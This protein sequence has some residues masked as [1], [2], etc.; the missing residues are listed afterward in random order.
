M[1]S[2]ASTIPKW[3]RHMASG[4]VEVAWIVLIFFLLGGGAAPEVN[5]P[6]YVC[7]AK[8]FWDAGF[9]PRDLFLRSQDAHAVF[10]GA[11]GGVTRWVDLPTAAWIGRFAGWLLLAAA[12]YRLSAAL[13][14]HRGASLL[15][16][17]LWATLVQRMH[18]SGEWIIG[19]IEGK[20]VAYALVIWGLSCWVQGR[21]RWAWTLV[22]G[23]AT[24]HVLV[25]GWTAIAMAFAAVTQ[26]A[27]GRRCL[28]RSWPGIL[29]GG[30]ISLAG[31][32]PAL[33]LNADVSADVM[34]RAT[35][36]YVFDRISHH[37]LIRDFDRLFV[38]RHLLLMG[39][40]VVLAQ[41]LRGRPPFARLAGVVWGAM[42]LVLVGATLDLAL[43]DSVWTA[44][45]MRYYWFRLSDVFVP[46]GVSL[47]VMLHL[48]H[49]QTRDRRLATAGLALV[50]LVATGNLLATVGQLHAATLPAA[51]RQGG[52]PD[53]AAL[54]DWRDVC[55]WVRLHL[56]NDALCLTP[57]DHQT[58]KWYAQR[59]ELVTWKDVPQDA[60]SIVQWSER[61][62]RVRRWQQSR[63]EAEAS[64][65]F[66][67][68][69]HDYG[70]DH[71]VARWPTPFPVA[72][73]QVIYQN[74]GYAVLRLA[75]DD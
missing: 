58:F 69:Q 71:V 5:E 50:L 32:L 23:A 9:C 54:A 45:L 27:D 49:W 17:T 74:R 19:G 37:L 25:G 42:L 15:S 72:G 59:S 31:L 33:R 11:F 13:V 14:P 2:A 47:A 75:A 60:R 46:L 35:E 16:A 8:H 10:F 62:A 70:F 52:I 12:W 7:R 44:R 21:W 40:F 24:F 63:D 29:L 36:I 61:L 53:R 56:S 55:Q 66:R 6:H 73:G 51:D 34:Q 4:A 26:G 28:L 22:G 39:V 57:A 41:P 68:L 67:A 65:R 20:V 38:L 3:P 1:C 48:L 30:V 18:M 64:E 43:P